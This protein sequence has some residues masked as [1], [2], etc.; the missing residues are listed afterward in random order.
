ME[1]YQRIGL[2]ETTVYQKNITERKS[3]IWMRAVLICIFKNRLVSRIYNEFQQINNKWMNEWTNTIPYKK[4]HK[5]F[6]WPSYQTVSKW[7]K[8]MK[9]Y[10]VSLIK[11]KCKLNPLY[12]F[13][14]TH[15]YGEDN[16]RYTIWHIGKDL[17]QLEL[18]YTVRRK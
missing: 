3:K 1:N 5:W 6:E 13:L 17:E 10:P 15:Q 9:S 12:I 18:S 16:K 7:Q 14:N 8:N 4:M 2:N 11:Q